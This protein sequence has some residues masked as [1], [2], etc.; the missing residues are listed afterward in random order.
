MNAPALTFRAR[1]ARL[2]VIEPAPTF[3]CALEPMSDDE[4]DDIACRSEIAHEMRLAAHGRHPVFAGALNCAADALTASNDICVRVMLDVL[5]LHCTARRLFV[6]FVDALTARDFMLVTDALDAWE[7]SGEME[8]ALWVLTGE[9]IDG[10][11]I[12][13][14]MS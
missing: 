4:V 13:E 9:A 6:A 11:D 14:V 5:P 10:A 2:R 8:P 7:R 3:P 12:S 1:P